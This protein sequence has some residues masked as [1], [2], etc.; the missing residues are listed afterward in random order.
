MQALT[1][2][3]QG[4]HSNLCIL[5]PSDESN[6]L[7]SQLHILLFLKLVLLFNLVDD[8]LLT[9]LLQFPSQ[10][11]LIQYEVSLL[12]V[13][14]DVQLADRSK[15][16][17]QDLNIPVNHLQHPQLVISLVHSTEEEAGIP[18]VHHTKIFILNKVAHF[19]FSQQN[20]RSQ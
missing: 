6:I 8:S 13:E 1:R 14:D 20:G 5:I 17:I 7:E 9:G 10:D 3:S 4:F 18:L 19:R 12:K 15:I 2:A 16:L 11:E